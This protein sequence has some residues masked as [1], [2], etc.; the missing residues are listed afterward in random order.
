MPRQTQEDVRTIRDFDI[1]HFILAHIRPH[2][3]PQRLHLIQR[4]LRPSRDAAAVLGLWFPKRKVAI[5][6]PISAAVS[7]IFVILCSLAGTVESP[8]QPEPMPVQRQA[9]GFGINLMNIVLTKPPQ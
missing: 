6:T 3:I 5:F 8:W 9:R 2:A 1:H 4:H 7:T